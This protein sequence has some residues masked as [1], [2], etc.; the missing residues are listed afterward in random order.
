MVIFSVITALILLLLLLVY[1]QVVS[2]SAYYPDVSLPARYTRTFFKS[3]HLSYR[4][5]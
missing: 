3:R 4:K 2:K 5:I 1:R